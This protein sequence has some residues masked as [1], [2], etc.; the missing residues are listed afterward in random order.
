MTSKLKGEINGGNG[1]RNA[2]DMEQLH[3]TALSCGSSVGTMDWLSQEYSELYPRVY[4]N[5]FRWRT[6]SSDTFLA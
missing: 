5:C 6:A 1:T 2:C 3:K 4:G